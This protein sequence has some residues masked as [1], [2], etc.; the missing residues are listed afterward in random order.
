MF[1]GKLKIFVDQIYIPKRLHV[2]F[3]LVLSLIIP[4]LISLF[5]FSGVFIKTILLFVFIGLL[6]DLRWFYISQNIFKLESKLKLVWKGGGYQ[7]Y[8]LDS[9]F[10]KS[11]NH[12]DTFIFKPQKP[13]P[14]NNI[15]SIKSWKL[16]SGEKILIDEVICVLKISDDLSTSSVML[17]SNM[18]GVIEIHK[19][20]KLLD[21]NNKFEVKDSDYL[22]TIHKTQS[23]YSLN[24]ITTPKFYFNESIT[25]DSLSDLQPINLPCA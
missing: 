15:V 10:V 1:S 9:L 16:N 6:S 25:T 5:L 23:E 22:F 19:P 17:K 18:E 12:G 7:R 8:L 13:L 2:R 14:T 24:K 3:V 4:T 21:I 11:S 20:E